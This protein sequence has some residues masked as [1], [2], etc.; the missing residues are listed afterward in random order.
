MSIVDHKKLMISV[1]NAIKSDTAKV[2]PRIN[3]TKYFT[4]K[5]EEIGIKMI[6]KHIGNNSIIILKM[7][8]EIGFRIVNGRFF[9]EQELNEILAVTEANHKFNQHNFLSAALEKE[10]I[11]LD[12]EFSNLNP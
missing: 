6:V 11:D 12:A 2:I 1:V 8:I 7:S 10:Q 3:D 4:A 5:N 9:F